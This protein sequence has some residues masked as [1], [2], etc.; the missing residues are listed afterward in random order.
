MTKKDVVPKQGVFG[1]LQL[2]MLVT[3]S[4]SVHILMG[5]L[6]KCFAINAKTK[7]GLIGI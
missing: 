1:T 2:A 4:E 5:H 6:K 3:F 7:C